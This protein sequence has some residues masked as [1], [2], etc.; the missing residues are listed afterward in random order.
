MRAYHFVED[1]RVIVD[2]IDGDLDGADIVQL[3]VAVVR[4]SHS[5]VHLFFSAWLITVEHLTNHKPLI[6]FKV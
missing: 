6:E 5:Q 1:W 2:I 3:G 4:C